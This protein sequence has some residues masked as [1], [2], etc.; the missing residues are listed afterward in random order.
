MVNVWQSRAM[1]G[2]VAIFLLSSFAIRDVSELV[3]GGIFLCL[4]IIAA[5]QVFR[6]GDSLLFYVLFSLCTGFLFLYIFFV[7]PH[8]RLL[9]RDVVY[10]LNIFAGVVFVVPFL[11]NGGQTVSIN[12]RYFLLICAIAGMAISL[13]TSAIIRP[14]LTAYHGIVFLLVAALLRDKATWWWVF[15]GAYVVMSVLFGQ[16]QNMVLLVAWSAVFAM[17]F[18]MSP[19]L[20]TKLAVTGMVLLPILIAALFSVGYF[21]GVRDFDTKVRAYFAYNT[22]KNFLDAPGDMK[23]GESVV[24]YAMQEIGRST[25]RGDVDST[26]DIGTHNFFTTVVA[27]MGILGIPVAV[28]L[29]VLCF[30]GFRNQ[31]TRVSKHNRVL[32]S[33]TVAFV[34][35]SLSVNEG[36]LSFLYEPVILLPGLYSLMVFRADGMKNSSLAYVRRRES[37]LTIGRDLSPANSSRFE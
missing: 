34:F 8:G 7:S 4:A 15:L 35:V 21:H 33:Y 16:S 31:G 25:F 3:A 37:D 26:L 22:F 11:R 30:Y 27:K 20:I 13:A 5:I 18:V 9:N 10:F 32:Y 12:Q 14:H 2:Y 24:P 29:F 6:S 17:T 28:A 19:R 1:L 36:V 23:F